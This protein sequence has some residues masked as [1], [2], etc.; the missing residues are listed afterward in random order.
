MSTTWSPGQPFEAEAATVSL[1]SPQG[2]PAPSFYLSR[3]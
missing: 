3:A 2:S 1:A